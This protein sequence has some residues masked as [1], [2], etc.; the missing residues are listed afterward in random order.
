MLSKKQIFILGFIFLTLL[1]LGTYYYLVQYPK[2][3][4]FEAYTSLEVGQEITQYLDQNSK[5]F[6]SLELANI[7]KLVFR[8]RE[9]RVCKILENKNVQKT[10][11]YFLS[12][13]FLESGCSKLCLSL[14]PS[15][16]IRGNFCVYLDESKI[17]TSKDM[18]YFW[19]N[20]PNAKSKD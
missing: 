7:E 9:N 4:T 13:E 15:L 3:V 20:Y 10:E 5:F 12:D 19:I 2:S 18:P 11:N 17:I 6:E 16:I 1:S 8:T 14:M